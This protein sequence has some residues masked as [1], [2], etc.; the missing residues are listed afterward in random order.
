MTSKHR[1]DSLFTGHCTTYLLHSI[2]NMVRHMI[3]KHTGWY[4]YLIKHSIVSPYSLVQ[5]V[6]S[7]STCM[8][9]TR[10]E[11]I[12]NL[13]MMC[14]PTA[15]YRKCGKGSC[16]YTKSQQM[17]MHAAITTIIFSVALCESQKYP[18]TYQINQHPPL[19]YGKGKKHQFNLAQ[20]E[21]KHRTHLQDNFWRYVPLY[22]A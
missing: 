19:R 3:I 2:E 13:C 21:W 9:D 20:F 5:W 15:V 8:R 7:L 12:R 14:L 10:S 18:T 6:S 1:T 17:K 16:S 4:Y 11:A 22:R